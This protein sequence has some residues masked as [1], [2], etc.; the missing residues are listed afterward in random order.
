MNTP[1]LGNILQKESYLAMIKNAEGSNLFRNLYANIEGKSVDI[2]QDGKK[3]CTFFV[4]TV[5]Y[6]FYLIATPHA[7][8]SG[9]EQDL[10]SSGWRKTETPNAG[11]VLVWEP[12]LQSDT[13]TAHIGFYLGEDQAISNDWQT[14]LPIKHHITYGTKSDG[15]PVRAITAI[16][17]HDFTK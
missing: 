3:S 2:V 17:T 8:V 12:I 9:L 16:Y 4:S 7:T 1:P 13:V 5:L 10:V 11:D 14:R 15:T 6:S